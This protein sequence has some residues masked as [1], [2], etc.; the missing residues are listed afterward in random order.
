MKTK[1]LAGAALFA[2]FAAFSATSA[3]AEAVGPYVALD[4]GYHQTNDFSLDGRDVATGNVIN[5][6]VKFKGDLVGFARLGYQVT[7]HW[8][9]EAEYGYHNTPLKS[10]TTTPGNAYLNQSGSADANSFMGNLIY[11]FLPDS[12]INPFVGVGGGALQSN[13]KFRGTWPWPASPGPWRP[14]GTWT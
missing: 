14:V 9:V 1:L 12:K 7:P 11:D 4:V 8:R 13:S 3:L 6:H 2:A 5:P 10:M